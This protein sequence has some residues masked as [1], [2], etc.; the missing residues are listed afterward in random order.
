MVPQS[1][2]QIS[3][4]GLGYVGLP[5]AVALARHYPVVGYDL[6]QH[7]VEELRKGHDR[8]HEVP[9]ADVAA[10]TCRYEYDAAKMTG[11][12]LFI[13]AVPTPVHEDR[14][15]DFG[16]VVGACNAVGPLLKP[17][18]IVCFES[19]VYPGATEEICAPILE[20]L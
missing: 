1:P 14:K 8:T 13:V 6:S 15:P 7:R 3:V 20:R 2:R 17:G 9:D 12:D 11:S 5:L 4:I 10:S 19:T 16:P 18:A